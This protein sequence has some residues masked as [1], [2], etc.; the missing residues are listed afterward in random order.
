MSNDA[1]FLG[2]LSDDRAASPT[3]FSDDKC[4]GKGP[5][6]P[7]RATC[8]SAANCT[9]EATYSARTPRAPG[10]NVAQPD[11]IVFIVAAHMRC[12]WRWKRSMTVEDSRKN[13]TPV[14]KTEAKDYGATVNQQ[15]ADWRK[16]ITEDMARVLNANVK[17][18][19][20]EHREGK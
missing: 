12:L 5:A 11:A 14:S 9:A 15:I 10:L 4:H 20:A 7:Q 16:S 3:E 2:N 1:F 18:P 8:A 13:S 19:D 17:N 6:D